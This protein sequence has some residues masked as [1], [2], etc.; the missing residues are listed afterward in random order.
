MESDFR[1]DG[2]GLTW[3]INFHDGQNVML[4]I[5]TVRLKDL[6]VKEISERGLFPI[7]QFYLRIFEPLTKQKLEAFGN[8]AK[9]LLAEL[10]RAVDSGII[11]V[12]IGLQMQDNIHKTAENVLHRSKL[13]GVDLTMATNVVETLPWVDYREVFKQLEER[14]RNEG[15]EKGR[16]AM[17]LEIAL[18]VFRESGKSPSVTTAASLRKLGISDNII[19]EARAKYQSEMAGQPD[20]KKTPSRKR[21]EKEL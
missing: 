8:T 16:M 12:H 20:K 19:E 5:P 17:S 4:N 1:A 21:S 2:Q 9:E 10:K 14:G 6:S 3:N 15:I 13:K 7:G 11:P 18:N